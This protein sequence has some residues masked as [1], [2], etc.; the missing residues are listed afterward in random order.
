M[1]VQI[2]FRRDPAATWTSINPILALAE[3]GFETDTLKFK[4]GTGTTPWTSLSYVPTAGANGVLT[5]DANSWTGQQTFKELKET[6]YPIIDTAAFEIDPVN[7]SIQTI[8][9]G[10]SRTPAATN[11][12][13]GQSVI[14]GIDAGAAYAVTW[15]TVN[16]TWIKSGGSGAAPLLDTTGKTWIVLW[17]VS[18]TMYAAYLG[19]G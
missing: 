13:S 12:E 11:F 7:G 1:A 10:A 5:T 6:V 18:N 4:L 17:K 16:P 3:L 15:T 8:T 14:L 19:A 2:Q 9:L